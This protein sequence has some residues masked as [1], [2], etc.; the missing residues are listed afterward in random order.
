MPREKVRPA[1]AGLMLILL[2]TP[3]ITRRNFKSLQSYRRV[4]TDV[5][6]KRIRVPQC[7]VF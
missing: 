7:G 4:D 5:V 3:W 1:V 2:S 6:P